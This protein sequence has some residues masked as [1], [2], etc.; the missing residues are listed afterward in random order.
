MPMYTTRLYFTPILHAYVVDPAD[1]FCSDL[2]RPPNPPP[3]DAPK[4]FENGAL[5]PPQ[6]LEKLNFYFGRFFINSDKI[7]IFQ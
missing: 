7:V 2:Y 3:P 1:Q 4:I 5:T 6:P